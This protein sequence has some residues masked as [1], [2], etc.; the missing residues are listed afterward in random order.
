[1]KKTIQAA[2]ALFLM[3]AAA[4]C[5]EKN[6]ETGTA[7]GSIL[8]NVVAPSG[9]STR[10]DTQVLASCENAVNKVQVFV[11][12]DAGNIEKN[13]VMTT[14][15][16][17]IENVSTGTKTVW[18]VVN[19]PD[20]TG[21]TTV[22]VLKAKALALADN[23][24]DGGTG[25]VM[26]GSDNCSVTEGTSSSCTI[27]VSRYVSRVRLV[28][29]TNGCAAA[30]GSIT[31]NSAMIIN[32]TSNQNVA[33]DATHAAG[34]YVNRYGRAEENPLVSEHVIDGVTYV[35]QVPSLTWFK[36]STPLSIAAGATQ[37]CGYRFYAFSNSASHDQPFSTTFA[38][39][40]T[41]LA[42][43][44]TVNGVQYW[45]SVRLDK[46]LERNKAY[47]VTLTISG[48]GSNDPQVDPT[49]G[50]FSASISVTEWQDGGDYN[51]N[52]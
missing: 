8:F 11:F 32:V 48:K 5:T 6:L 43:S 44:A 2:V 7:S 25:F 37:N 17:T 38:P 20:L 46:G 49:N 23:S 4:S 14:S 50:G 22:N 36:P 39:N 40:D 45:Y 33:G 34:N 21:V 30:I 31:V 1:M 24:T 29:V 3:L 47:D 10:A 12:D 42:V 15:S 27:H 19:G 35:A 41:R 18:A 16:G 9:S 26:G 28:S 51:V 52:Y 13:I